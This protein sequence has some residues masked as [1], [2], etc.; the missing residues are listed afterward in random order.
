MFESPAQELSTDALSTCVVS[1][2]TPQPKIQNISRKACP[3]PS[4]R[5]AKHVQSDVKGAAKKTV[6][7]T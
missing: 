2:A 6:I 5:D 4:P 3:E 1:V 7:R